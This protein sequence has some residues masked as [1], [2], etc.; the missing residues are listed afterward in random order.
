MTDPVSILEVCRQLSSQ[1]AAGQALLLG[2]SGLHKLI[3]RR[4]A[5][6]AAHEFAG[7][8]RG[9]APGAV[10]VLAMIELSAGVL[11]WIPPS[12]TAGAALAALIWGGYSWLLLRAVA[13][14]RRDVDCGCSW[15]AA[16]R[17]LGAWQI[18]RSAALAFLAVPVALVSA[19]YGAAVIDATQI[20]A[21]CALLA[22][23]AALDHAM[24]LEPPRAGELL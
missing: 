8:P 20:L 24:A 15:G 19:L 7:V 6:V 10:A 21:A 17:S 3:G 12:R 1:L 5:R 13:Q 18:S 2:A 14:G 11:L 4:R 16:H 22:L 9:L 23:Y